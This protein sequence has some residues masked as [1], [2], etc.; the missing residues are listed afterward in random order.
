MYCALF[1]AGVR[2]SWKKKPLLNLRCGWFC[3]EARGKLAGIL[4]AIFVKIR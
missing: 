2:S 4:N 1:A 3:R